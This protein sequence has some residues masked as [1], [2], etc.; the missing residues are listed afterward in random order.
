MVRRIADPFEWCK[1]LRSGRPSNHSKHMIFPGSRRLAVLLCAALMAGTSSPVFAQS[2]SEP[3]PAEQKADGSREA[4][5]EI[6]EISRQMGGGPA[7]NTECIW[8]GRR[9]LNLL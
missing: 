1:R 2:T 6:A 7:A 9:V 4:A 3:P 8:L 5:K